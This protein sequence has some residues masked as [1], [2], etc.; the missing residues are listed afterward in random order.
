MGEEKILRK[1]QNDRIK[2]IKTSL[3]I[4]LEN[5][6]NEDDGTDLENDMYADM[7]NLWESICDYL[8]C[9]VL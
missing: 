7:K 6:V 3:E 9:E 8:D 2:Q 1:I 4:A 5:A